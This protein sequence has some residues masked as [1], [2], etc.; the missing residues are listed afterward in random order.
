MAKIEGGLSG[1][2]AEV[3]TASRSLNVRQINDDGSRTTAKNIDALVA[4]DEGLPLVVANDAN[5]R[6]LRA[7]R[8]GNIGTTRH[9]PLFVG[10]YDGATL[11]AAQFISSLATQTLAQAT[12]TGVN[13]NNGAS[14]AAGGSAIVTSLKQFPFFPRGPVLLRKRIRLFKG[15]TN[16]VAEWGFGIP[17]GNTALNLGAAWQY[18]ADGTLKPVFFFNGTLT[19]AGTDISASIDSTRYYWFDIIVSDDALVFTVQDPA[20]RLIISEQTL[21][22]G[23]DAARLFAAMRLPV[24]E[25]TYVGGVAA[26]APATQLF[27]GQTYV[28][29]LDVDL[30]R[31]F[32]EFEASLGNDGLRNPQSG[33]Q[34]PAHSNNTAGGTLA[35]SNTVPGLATLGGRF[36]FAATASSLTDYVLFS[37]Q[38]PTGYQFMVT[39][40][41]IDMHNDVVASAAQ[42]VFEWSL[43]YDG[44]N[45][46]LAA[47]GHIREFIG[48]QTLANAA[49]VGAPILPSI[50]EKFNRPRKTDSGRFLAVILRLPVGA[51]TATELF[52]GVV[53]L[54][55]HFSE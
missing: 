18:A 13:L 36:A 2:E 54:N 26:T 1:V 6:F 21:N 35:L 49:V 9:S 42:H 24:F 17:V 40:V 4:A 19:A 3:H 20:T 32:G 33:V 39:D 43:G 31:S 45:S 12:A 11:N 50:K 29:L 38:V 30:Q 52:R 7:D 51:A 34:N 16:G 15:G 47:G 14:V 55:G 28:G 27:V 44:T 8:M 37:Y 23:V 22:I 53:N 48:M 10:T 41:S 25:R 5:W 46:S